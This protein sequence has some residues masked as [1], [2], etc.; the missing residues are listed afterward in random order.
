MTLGIIER[1]LLMRK[2]QIA[3]RLARIETI[4]EELKNSYVTK[5][6]FKPIRLVVY[7]F[8]GLILTGVIGGFLTGYLN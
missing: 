6:E 8:V 3:E 4:L 2:D 1:V 7:G 5:Q